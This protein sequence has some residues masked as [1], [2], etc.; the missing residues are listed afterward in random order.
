M[1]QAIH[2]ILNGKELKAWV[3]KEEIHYQIQPN[4]QPFLQMVRGGLKKI[5]LNPS[6]I[7]S[8]PPSDSSTVL[9]EKAA[10]K[11]A[12]KAVK[13]EVKVEVKKEVK[14]VEPKK[15]VKKLVKRGKRK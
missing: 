15:L 5:Y 6:I 11:A 2:I 12:E 3:P 14:K 7:S 9:P 13:V 4:D 8:A 1:Y 10:E